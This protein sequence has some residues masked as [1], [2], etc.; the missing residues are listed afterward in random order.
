VHNWGNI[1]PDSSFITTLPIVSVLAVSPSAHTTPQLGTSLP[2]HSCYLIAK[3][4]FLE[5][6]EMTL[7]A[8]SERK[9]KPL[10]RN[11][12]SLLRSPLSLLLHLLHSSS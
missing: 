6:Q 11:P 3:E 2:I 12:H 9:L 7:P 4:N 10:S 5:A 1:P 8:T